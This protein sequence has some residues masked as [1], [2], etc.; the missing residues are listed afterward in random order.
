MKKNKLEKVDI[1]KYVPKNVSYKKYK[2][3]SNLEKRAIDMKEE[4]NKIKAYEEIGKPIETLF[5][6]ITLKE[7]A[8]TV[9]ETTRNEIKIWIDY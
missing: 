7:P 1:W 5:G 8:E 9:M 4:Y 6:N 2:K 3:L